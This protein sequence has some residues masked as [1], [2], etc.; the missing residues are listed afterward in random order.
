MNDFQSSSLFC[1]PFTFME[2]H[3]EEKLSEKITENGI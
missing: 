1:A 2:N 3:I